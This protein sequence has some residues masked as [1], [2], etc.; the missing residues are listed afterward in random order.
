MGLK[1]LTLKRLNSIMAA[2]NVQG[3]IVTPVAETLDFSALAWSNYAAVLMDHCIS[4]PSL[5]SVT[6]LE[7]TFARKRAI[8][9][10]PGEVELITARLHGRAAVSPYAG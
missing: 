2:R 1:I 3:V 8:N 6:S 7:R 9:S 5:C 4:R 10:T